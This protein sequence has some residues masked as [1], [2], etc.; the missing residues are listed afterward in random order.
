MFLKAAPRPLGAGVLRER[1][2]GPA[3]RHGWPAAKC[4]SKQ[5]PRPLGRVCFGYGPRALHFVTVG[6]RPNVPQS[7]APGPWGGCASGAGHGYCVSSRLACG[8]MFL[9]AAPR[10]LGRVCF[11]YGPR[12]LHFVTVGLRP[13]AP[14]SSAPA[15][16]GGCVASAGHGRCVSS[17]L[18]CGQMLLKA[19]PPGPWHEDRQASF[20]QRI[21]PM[22]KIHERSECPCWHCPHGP[23]RQAR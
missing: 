7:S 13:N 3:F 12:A 2:T 21:L 5:H 19:A 10:P 23:K 17:R 4:S 9:T 6:L 16:G 11:G 14:Q 15:L 18:A 1:A 22:L 20:P 8:Q